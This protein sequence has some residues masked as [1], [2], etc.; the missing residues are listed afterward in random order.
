M[1]GFL[2]TFHSLR[3]KRPTDTAPNSIRQITVVDDQG[4]VTSPNSSPRRII[5]APP[6]MNKLPVQSIALSPAKTGVWG[7]GT[8]KK[9]SNTTNTTA[10]TGTARLIS[11]DG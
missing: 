10:P 7:F 8:F 1:I 4:Y 5:N 3:M 2:A 11:L 6:T 9:K